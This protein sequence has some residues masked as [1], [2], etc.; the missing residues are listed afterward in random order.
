MTGRWLFHST[1]AAD[2]LGFLPR[3]RGELI[4]LKYEHRVVHFQA[5][6]GICNIVFTNARP[7]EWEHRKDLIC[8]L[9]LN[10]YDHETSVTLGERGCVEYLTPQQADARY[11]WAQNV[12]REKW[13]GEGHTVP[14]GEHELPSPLVPKSEPS[15]LHPEDLVIIDLD[16]Y[17]T[18]TDQSDV[19]AVFDLSNPR[20]RTYTF[21]DAFCGAGGVSCGARMAGLKIKWGTDMDKNA[22][23]TYQLNFHGDATFIEQSPFNDFMTNREEDIQVDVC[24]ASPPCQP[25]SPAHT[26]QNQVRDET[27]SA[28]VFAPWDILRRV[29]PRVLTMEETS[30]LLS[31]FNSTLN[32]VV[33]DMIEIGY[34]ARWG[35]VDC[36]HYGIP[37]TRKRLIVVAA[38]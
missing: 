8:R 31:G 13:R 23:A 27:N 19:K 36:S 2:V 11:S 12:L 17:E 35:I 29:K 9:A 20:D 4:W 33:Q 22:I 14:L 25:F 38:G 5:V 30:W 34:S 15:Q 18:S 26:I 7:K 3:L 16:N 6:K 28:C 37:S 21:G 24:H 10:I 1:L 32:R